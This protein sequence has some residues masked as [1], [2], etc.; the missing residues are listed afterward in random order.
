MNHFDRWFA[1]KGDETHRL[2]YPLNEDSVIFDVGAFEGMWAEKVYNK[3]KCNV[4]CFEPVNSFFYK[5]ASRLSSFKKVRLFECGVSGESGSAEVEIIADAS[6]AFTGG[7]GVKE[8]ISIMS[9]K[10]ALDMA[11]NKKVDLLKINIEGAE[12]DLLDSIVHNK[13]IMERIVNLQIQFH[14]F[15]PDAHSR[16]DRIRNYLGAT[17]EETYNYPFVWENWR[18]KG[19]S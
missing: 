19:A 16:R 12:F 13:D 17:H 4:F 6:S 1:D 14:D 10:S 8:R 5:A 18:L 3:F 11:P 7:N 9:I 15:V 2:N